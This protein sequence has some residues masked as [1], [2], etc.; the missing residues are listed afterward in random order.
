MSFDPM[1]VEVAVLLEVIAL[2]PDHLLTTSELIRKMSG[3]RDED[4]ELRDAIRELKGS[5]LL[6]SIGEV[7]APTHAA[8]RA[9][10]LL[11]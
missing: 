5:G 8:L 2:H 9:H 3:E 10:T 4:R 7:L 1:Q 11:L 6:R